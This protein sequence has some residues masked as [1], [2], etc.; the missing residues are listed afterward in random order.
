[1]LTVALLSSL[2]FTAPRLLLLLL[3][4]LVS[5]VGLSHAL[6]KSSG[7]RVGLGAIV[8]LA[9]DLHDVVILILFVKTTKES[10]GCT[11]GSDLRPS[12]AL[13]LLAMHGV[14]NIENLTQVNST[15]RSEVVSSAGLLKLG[16]IKGLEHTIRLLHLIPRSRSVSGNPGVGQ[17]LGDC[18]SLLGI[19]GQQMANE[20]LGR[21]GDLVPPGRQESELALGNLLSKHLNALIVEW[22]ETAKESVQ[23]TTQSPHID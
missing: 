6:L 21:L 5:D 3:L 4:L 8:L 20:I 15:R 12:L 1:M 2:A 17:E 22:R 11:L 14:T 16:S 13:F 7:R 18:E 10:C 9:V 19:H 23:H